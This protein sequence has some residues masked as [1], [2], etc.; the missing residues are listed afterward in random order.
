MVLSVLPHTSDTEDVIE[1]G[2]HTFKTREVGLH[3]F[4]PRIPLGDNGKEILKAQQFLR[5]LFT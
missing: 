2:G 1:K 3:F 5:L 4:I